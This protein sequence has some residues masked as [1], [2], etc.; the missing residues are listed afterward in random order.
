MKVAITGLGSSDYIA[1]EQLALKGIKFSP[2]PYA[3]PQERYQAVIVSGWSSHIDAVVGR[4]L[5][6]SRPGPTDAGAVRRSDGSDAWASVR[7][8]P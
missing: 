8:R 3:N 6:F 7:A 4:D 2:M 5:G 1:I